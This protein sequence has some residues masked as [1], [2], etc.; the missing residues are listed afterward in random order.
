MLSLIII[1][2]EVLSE[3]TC[4]GLVEIGVINDEALVEQINI[5][6]FC[7]QPMRL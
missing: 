7:I 3:F 6:I 4:L 5:Y 1:T 2:A